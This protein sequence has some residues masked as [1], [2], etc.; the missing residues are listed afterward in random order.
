MVI[1]VYGGAGSGKSEVLRIL[2]E[3]HGALVISAD[4][5]AHQLYEKGEEGYLAVREMFG[6]S[7]LTE[8]E[9]DRR[10]LG[11]ILYAD[12]VKM[13]AVNAVIHPMVYR[14]IG[15]I[16]LQNP[17][18]LIIQEQAVLPDP[19]PAYVDSIW[20]IHTEAS[21]RRQRLK[22]TRGYTDERVDE[23]LRAQPTEAAFAQAADMI[24]ENNGTLK[25]LE[26]KIN[27]TLEYC[28]REQR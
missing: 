17:G 22:T 20:Y 21:I 10:K 23:I 3:K 24:I 8:G 13:K 27:E 12:P 28:K 18:R 11:N 16:V 4:Q 7:I 25:E 14:K 6:D 5:T 2:A 26:E 19:V 15:E 1:A 9:I